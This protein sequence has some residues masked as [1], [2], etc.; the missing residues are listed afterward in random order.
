MKIPLH[1]VKFDN[2]ENVLSL[3]NIM[4]DEDGWEI[5]SKTSILG[6]TTYTLYEVNSCMERS[7][8]E[9]FADLINAIKYALST[10]T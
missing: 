1:H 9:E 7:K 4:D 3:G 6:K 8:I 10:L 5:D 2:V